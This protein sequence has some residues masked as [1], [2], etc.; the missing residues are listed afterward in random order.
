MSLSRSYAQQNHILRIVPRQHCYIPGGS[1][2]LGLA[3]AQELTRRGAHVSIVA[4]N[5]TKL[6]EALKTLEAARSNAEQRLSMHSHS[7]ASGAGAKAALAEAC[8]AHGGA[9]PDA[10]FLCA[11]ASHPGF[12]VEMNEEDLKK[13]MD[14][15][16]WVQAWTAWV[17]VT[18]LC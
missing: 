13:G 12:F 16:Y 8:A 7:L 14:D 6:A 9:A 4:R 10:V 11:G 3:L 18:F 15:G 5:R 2:G 1:S 17:R